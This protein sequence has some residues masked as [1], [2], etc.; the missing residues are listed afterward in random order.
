MN[1]LK[2]SRQIQFLYFIPGLLWWGITLWLFT[3][4]GTTVPAFPW[5]A[6]LHADKIV[7]LVIF[8]LW[9]CLFYWPFLYTSIPNTERKRW[10]LLIALLGLTYGIAIEFIQ[11]W[12]NTGR[13]FEIA[14]V[15][16]DGMGC[17]LAYWLG[18]KYLLQ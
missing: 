17:W 3:L 15:L 10:F 6:K 9:C 1:G 5:L 11:R 2:T 12:M 16:A 18:K 4:P 8:A 13:A 14:D 7:H